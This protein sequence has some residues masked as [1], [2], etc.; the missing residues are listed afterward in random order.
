M[1]AKGV[2]MSRHSSRASPALRALVETDPAIAAL[3]LWCT[4]RDGA[5]TQTIGTTIVYGPESPKLPLYTQIGLAAHHILHVALRHPARLSDLHARLGAGFDPDLY[6]LCADALINEALLLADHALPRPAV[7]LTNLLSGTLGPS[8]SPQAALQEWDVDRLYFALG[9]AGANGQDSTIARGSKELDGN[10]TRGKA[11]AYA[12]QAGFTSD[13]SPA[14]GETGAEIPDK[15]AQD[16]RWRQHLSR[17]LDTGRIAGRGLGRIG[18]RILDIPEPRTPWELI[19]RRSLTRALTL[20]TQPSP[21]R[22]ARRWIV[23][24]AQADRMG[25]PT[26]GFEAGQKQLS[27]MPRIVLAIDA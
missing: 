16:A 10:D 25:R 20:Q 21:Y 7:T 13:L 5:Q 19:L 4:H 3:S 24:A 1:I 27:H 26:P 15:A 11:E 23:R 12:Q 18:H 9:T 2:P 17:A 6:N 22:P 8:A 14:P